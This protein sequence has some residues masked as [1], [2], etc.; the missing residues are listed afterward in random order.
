MCQQEPWLS[1]PIKFADQTTSSIL[2]FKLTTTAEGYYLICSDWIKVWYKAALSDE[3][4]QEHKQ[5]AS[6]IRASK[7]SDSL[8][9]IQDLLTKTSPSHQ[10]SATLSARTQE[11]E[12]TSSMKIENVLTITWKFHLTPLST[13]DQQAT[14]L[15]DQ[16]ILPFF[17]MTKEQAFK[18]KLLQ[19]NRSSHLDANTIDVSDYKYRSEYNHFNQSHDCQQSLQN[20]YRHAMARLYNKHDFS[21]GSSVVDHQHSAIGKRKVNEIINA[22]HISSSHDKDEKEHNNSDNTVVIDRVDN[23]AIVS[24][25]DG[26]N[27]DGVYV[28]SEEEIARRKAIEEKLAKERDKTKKKK[29]QF[30]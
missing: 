13:R 29:K 24:H 21:S 15:R 26:V 12:I 9:L 6:N 17:E 3:L 25:N 5:Y 27:D 1:I 4:S 11:L 2:F 16:F 7:T 10:H 28:E 19:N 8:T 20:T 14:F 30:A 22:D 18:L 23:A